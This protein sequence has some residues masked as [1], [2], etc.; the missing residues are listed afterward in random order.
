MPVQESGAGV[1]RLPPQNIDAERAVLGAL[2][3]DD[4][5]MDDILGSVLSRNGEEFYR[6]AHRR[7][8]EAMARIY[9]TREPVDLVTLSNQLRKTGELEAVG[10]EAYLSTLVS[11]THTAAHCANYAKIV[12]EKALLRKLIGA[13]GEIARES[14]DTAEDV[15]SFLD[16]AER[17][18]FAISQDKVRSDYVALKDLTEG[19]FGRLEV[20]S[21]SD[22]EFTGTTTGF[23]DL[24]WKTGGLQPGHFVIIAARPGMGKTSL[25]L[26]I[27]QSVGIRERDAEPVLI[28]SLEMSRQDLTMR[29][30][31]S[32]SRINADKFRF[33]KKIRDDDWAPLASAMDQLKNARVYLDDTAAVSVIEV[34]GKARRL[35]RKEN[36]RLGLVIVDY[37]Q[38]MRGGGRYDSREQ[39][40]ADISR[41]LK[42]LSKELQAPV[43]A[44]SQLNRQPEKREDKRPTMA[45]LR[46]SGSIEQ[47]AD[48]VILLYE[49]TEDEFKENRI[50][51]F[52]KMMEADGKTVEN[53][54]SN[55][56][57]SIV[58]NRNGPTGRIFM[59]F[60]KD[61]TRF[62]LFE[63]ERGGWG[64]EDA[65]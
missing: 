35:K 43:L 17:R 4:R 11:D 1:I 31:S 9:E 14:Y 28:F 47:D 23:S 50:T 12:R 44:L 60:R 26:N 19:V 30:L 38:L 25:A 32:L 55:I 5:L 2:L 37:L 54:T 15:D 56:T 52:P 7:I 6:D 61:V 57:V 8:F 3:L 49:T 63:R 13:A 27:A 46:E 18:I 59:Q 53:T 39:E 48:L 29:V 16:N 22:K 58:K 64:G 45:D 41:S 33:P 51:R 42:S 24:D 20:L 21:K 62:D 40:I 36:G 65:F 34:R 10:G